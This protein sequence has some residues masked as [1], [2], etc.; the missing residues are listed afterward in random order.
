MNGQDVS[1]VDCQNSELNVS[2]SSFVAGCVNF[3][4]DL[5]RSH[6]QPFSHKQVVVSDIYW[7]GICFN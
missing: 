5:I 6:D 7:N 4:L 1:C 3:W 2:D